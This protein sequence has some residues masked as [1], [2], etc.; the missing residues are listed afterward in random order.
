MFASFAN[1]LNFSGQNIVHVL[2]LCCYKAP[3]LYVHDQIYDIKYFFNFQ[4]LCGKAENFNATWLSTRYT[5]LPYSTVFLL[6]TRWKRQNFKV[7]CN[8]W[9]T[10]YSCISRRE[11]CKGDILY[12]VRL[13]FARLYD[14]THFQDTTQPIVSCMLITQECWTHSIK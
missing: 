1:K 10:L 8:F 3:C 12:Y 14:V 11:S 6:Q 9:H 5:L 7:D 13:C 4:A 2:V